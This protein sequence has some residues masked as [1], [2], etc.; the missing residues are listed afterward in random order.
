MAGVHPSTKT[1]S[2]EPTFPVGM[3]AILCLDLSL[4]I[5]N[6]AVATI[7]SAVSPTVMPIA[8]FSPFER[9]DEGVCGTEVLVGVEVGVSAGSS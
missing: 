9:L 8:A 7:P 2:G 3:A 5:R 6:S 1:P 4:K